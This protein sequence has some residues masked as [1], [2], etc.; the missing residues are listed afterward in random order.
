[1]A[2]KES[3]MEIKK[4]IEKHIGEEVSLITDRGKRKMQTRTG[5]VM[6]VFR[7]IFTVEINENFGNTRTASFSYSEVLTQD[8]E[9]IIN[10][11]QENLLVEEVNVL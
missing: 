8:V 1:M 9:F 2:N 4:Y 6:N 10:E 7:N 3:L 5:V 11:N